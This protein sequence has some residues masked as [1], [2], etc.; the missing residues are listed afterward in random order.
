M[1][2]TASVIILF[3]L[4]LFAFVK[5]AGP[6]ELSLNSVS[7]QTTDNFTV[8]GEGKVEIV[9]D[10]AVV[11]AG[12]TANAATVKQAQAE[13]NRRSNAINAALKKLGIKDA[14]LKTG[15]Y[16]IYP[17]YDYREGSQK[18]SGYNA[19]S[20]LVIK[21]REIDQANN[22]VD[23]A[24]AAGANQ[25]GGVSF[26]TDDPTKAEN[27]AR[28][29]AVADAK[30]KAEAAARIAGFNLGRIVNYS[31]NTGSNYPGPIPLMAR[32]DSALEKSVSTQVEPGTN[33]VNITVSLS[34][35]IR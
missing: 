2:H 15:N 31:E 29:L 6:F 26:Q 13:L 17:N 27:A 23:A 7:R 12:V 32:S 30:K 3:F 10:I 8:T 9:P 16:S 14:D 22:V 11:S 4:L 1:K 24:T 5:V 21:I 25:V 33:E 28:E 19:T 18:I 34:Y 20:S 35:E